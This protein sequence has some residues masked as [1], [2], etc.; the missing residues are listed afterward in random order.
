MWRRRAAFPAASFRPPRV[1]NFA[2]PFLVPRKIGAEKGGFHFGSRY[3]ARCPFLSGEFVVWLF[4]GVVRRVE[5]CHDYFCFR[6]VGSVY[7]AG[8]FCAPLGFRGGKKT[9]T[10]KNVQNGLKTRL[11]P[12]LGCFSGIGAPPFVPPLAGYRYDFVSKNYI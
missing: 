3:A 8:F 11:G 6:T 1:N 5:M 7:C 2:P 4:S 10:Q 12:F 9:A